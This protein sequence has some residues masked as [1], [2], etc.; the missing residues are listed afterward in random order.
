M[1]PAMPEP[2]PSPDALALDP[3]F[4]GVPFVAIGAVLIFL[5]IIVLYFLLRGKR[6][7]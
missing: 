1:E 2:P 7:Y 6:Q 4:Q 3:L 5:A